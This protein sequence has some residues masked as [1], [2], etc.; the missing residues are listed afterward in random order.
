MEP[1]DPKLFM[2]LILLQGIWGLFLIAA[3]FILKRMVSDLEKNTIATESIAKAVGNLNIAIATNLITTQEWEKLD[4]KV[5]NL[6][7]R[8]VGVEAREQMRNE[9]RGILEQQR[10]HGDNA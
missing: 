9:I 1:T 10:R 2:V 5:S 4:V 8:V 7:D 3:G 6:N